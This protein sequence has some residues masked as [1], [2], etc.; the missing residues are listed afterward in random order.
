MM[1]EQMLSSQSM[2]LP[3]N[4]AHWNHSSPCEVIQ[5]I[6]TETQDEHIQAQIKALSATS[7]V[8]RV[9]C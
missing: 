2:L 4:H 8:K 9:G 1:Q 3:W 6:L 5:C 7:Q